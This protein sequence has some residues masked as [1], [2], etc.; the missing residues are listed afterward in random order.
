MTSIDLHKILQEAGTNLGNGYAEFQRPYHL[1]RHD[2]NRYDINQNKSKRRKRSVL[3][4]E[5]GIP[6]DYIDKDSKRHLFYSWKIVFNLLPTWLGA[7]T[8][9]EVSTMLFNTKAYSLMHVPTYT[10]SDTWIVH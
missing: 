7:K 4:K 2:T 1:P 6:Y 5:R 3:S 10:Q 8:V 9:D